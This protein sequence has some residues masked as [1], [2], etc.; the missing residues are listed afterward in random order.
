MASSSVHWVLQMS[1]QS[2]LVSPVLQ[3]Q[4]RNESTLDFQFT[5]AYRNLA[6]SQ[7][8]WHLPPSKI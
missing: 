2:Q 3:S 7:S 5:L 4:V 8:V 6:L 1:G